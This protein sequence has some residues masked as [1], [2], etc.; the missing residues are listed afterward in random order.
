M[1]VIDGT[2]FHNQNKSARDVKEYVLIHW[3]LLDVRVH[4]AEYV[5]GFKSWQVN[6]RPWPYK[7]SVFFG[8]FNWKPSADRE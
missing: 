6:F 8:G 5:N 3:Y 2:R 7:C 4:V 1:E